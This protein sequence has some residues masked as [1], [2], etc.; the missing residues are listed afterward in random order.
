MLG[1]LVVSSGTQTRLYRESSRSA[2]L[3]LVSSTSLAESF[4]PVILD[5]RI[6]TTLPS[7]RSSKIELTLWLLNSSGH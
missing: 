4:V 2:P 3:P 6:S 5:A 7:V 1:N